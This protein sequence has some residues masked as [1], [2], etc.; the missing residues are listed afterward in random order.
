MGT[1]S[2]NKPIKVFTNHEIPIKNAIPV[3]NSGV[4]LLNIYIPL[5]LERLNLIEKNRFTT[6]ENQLNAVQYLQYVVTGLNKTDESL[7]PLNKVLC[8]LSLSSSVPDELEIPEDYKKLIDG[9]IMAAIGYWPSIGNC[10][11]DGFRGNWLVRDGLL[12]E[13]ENKWELTVE[14]RPYDLL[15]HKSPFSFTIIKYPWMNKPLRVIWLI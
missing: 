9:L 13:L 11:I 8:G 12:V 10:S 14:R 2:D 6:I 3:R 1:P 15:I 4:V 5:L 7:L